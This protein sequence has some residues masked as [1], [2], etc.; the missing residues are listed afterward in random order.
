MSHGGGG[1]TIKMNKVTRTFA[2]KAICLLDGINNALFTDVYWKF[3]RGL[4]VKFQGRPNYICSSVY[5]DGQGFNLISIGRDVVISR[6]VMLLTHD[7]SIETA[8]HSVGM[9]SV[10]RSIKTDAGISI[11]NNSFV[12]ARASL[13]PGTSIGDNCIIGACAVVKGRV[14]DNSI[15]IGNPAKVV[16]RTEELAMQ[17]IDRSN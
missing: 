5:F 4:G 10:D 11:G 3:L 17:F 8:L 9:G 15:V 7:Y 6:E 16:K 2:K 14:P 13:L 12:G 1:E